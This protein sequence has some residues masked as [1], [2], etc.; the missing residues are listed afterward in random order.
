MTNPPDCDWLADQFESHRR[1]LRSVAYRMLGS[2]AE[3]DDVVQDAWLRLSRADAGDVDNLRAW[4]TTVVAR[5]SLDTLRKR[6]R[7]PEDPSGVHLPD[8]I[9]S[10]VEGPGPED[11]VVAADAVG[12][13]LIVVL[14]TLS[15]P[16][17]LAFVL[18]DM[19]GLP[20]AQIAPILGRS[21]AATRQLASRGRRRVRGAG[22]SHSIADRSRQ[23]TLVEAFLAASQAGDFEALVRVLDPDVA[24]RADTGTL[25]PGAEREV[26]GAGRV[27]ELAH[28]F[29]GLAGGARHALVNGTPGL[30]VYAAGRPYAV[31]AF[32]VHDD[33]ITAIDIV[34][35]PDRLRRVV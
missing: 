3:A 7:R 32:T 6:T 8:P 12:L 14:D 33:R 29:K 2:V 15:P 10:L 28:G 19:F 25:F 13:A 11:D 4:L 35:D 23:R 27:G 21:E 26:V 9:V 31:L 30:V 20:F 17:R 5:L 34:A 22:V 16:E 24:L 18:H 1:Y